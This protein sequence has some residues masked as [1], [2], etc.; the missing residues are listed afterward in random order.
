[1]AAAAAAATIAAAAAM[2]AVVAEMPETGVPAGT[3]LLSAEFFSYTGKQE[4]RQLHHA[5]KAPRFFDQTIKPFKAKL[6]E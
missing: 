5:L 3:L 6:L 2:M 1:M 4:L